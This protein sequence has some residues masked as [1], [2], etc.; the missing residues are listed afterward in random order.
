MSWKSR[1]F[2]LTAWNHLL[3]HISIILDTFTSP[4]H[5]YA[6]TH[7]PSF[8]LQICMSTANHSPGTNQSQ[9]GQPHPVRNEST[10]GS[11]VMGEAQIDRRSSTLYCHQPLIDWGSP[12]STAFLTQ[13]EIS[14]FLQYYKGVCLHNSSQF[15]SSS[16]SFPRTEQGLSF[17]FAHKT[18]QL[19]PRSVY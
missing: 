18:S 9:P 13:Q 16:P 4:T 3:D 8:L 12:W 1:C 15:R 7:T 11:R 5:T 14:G 2:F 10:A 6:H 19:H 17:L